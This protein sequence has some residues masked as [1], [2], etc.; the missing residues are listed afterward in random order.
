MQIYRDYPVQGR[1]GPSS[2]WYRKINSILCALEIRSNFNKTVS[3]EKH[4]QYKNVAVL[5]EAELFLMSN[6]TRY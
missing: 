2:N 6:V 3:A 1:L 5:S 4:L